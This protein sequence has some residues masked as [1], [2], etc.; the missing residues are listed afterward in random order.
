MVSSLDSQ[1]KDRG[2]IPRR[3]TM[4]ILHRIAEL[5]C[6]TCDCLT[7]TSNI[8]CHHENCKYRIACELETALFA[9]E[10]VLTYYGKENN[11][12]KVDR[13]DTVETELVLAWRANEHGYKAAQ[14]ILKKYFE[15]N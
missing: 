8:E 4:N 1:S 11:W 14:D 9:L 13:H 6:G 10:S 7:K 12:N 15:D 3:S 5:Q 2:S